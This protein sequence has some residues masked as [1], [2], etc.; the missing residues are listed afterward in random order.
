ML[1]GCMA[2]LMDGTS[3]RHDR[4]ARFHQGS[5]FAQPAGYYV[6]DVPFFSDDTDQCGPAALAS[7]L[8]FWGVPTDPTQVRNDVYTARLRGSLPIDL[9]VSAQA[10]GLTADAYQGSLENVESEL[11]AGRPLIAFLDLGF[12]VFKQGHYVVVTGYDTRREGLYVHSGTRRNL[13]VPYTEFLNKW[14]KA[15]RWTLRLLPKEHDVPGKA[16][17]A[18][19]SG[20]AG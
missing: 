2:P 20:W 17:V 18:A 5:G 11:S 14:D 1:A 19:P 8:T 7:V 9:I 4:D 10:H 15:G 6:L 13:F 12:F 3:H 16:G